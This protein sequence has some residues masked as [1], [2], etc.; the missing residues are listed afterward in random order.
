ML[1]VGFQG[2][3]LALAGRGAADGLGVQAFLR[4]ASADHFEGFVFIISLV[5]VLQGVLMLVT[6]GR[7]GISGSQSLDKQT[8][9]H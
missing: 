8:A 3:A 6:L 2:R 9:D 4:N 5:L 7:P 1:H